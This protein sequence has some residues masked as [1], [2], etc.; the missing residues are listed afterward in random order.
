MLQIRKVKKPRAPLPSPSLPPDPNTVDI[1]F[2]VLGKQLDKSLAG[3]GAFQGS[4]PIIYHR[5]LATDTKE[6][7]RAALPRKSLA[8]KP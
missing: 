4:H 6:L 1:F 8:K 7:P 5:L 3:P 2:Q